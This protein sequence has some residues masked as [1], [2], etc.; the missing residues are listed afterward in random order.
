M[1]EHKKDQIKK[2]KSK[3][4]FHD[5]DWSDFIVVPLVSGIMAIA[6]FIMHPYAGVLG[7]LCAGFLCYYTY[8]REKES[9]QTTLVAIENLNQDFDE[10]TKS[11]VFSMP[12]PIAIL[13][14]SGVF[15][16]YNTSFKNLFN[17]ES[18][19]IGESHEKIFDGISLDAFDKKNDIPFSFEIGDSIYLFYHNLVKKGD[20]KTV[21]LYGIDNTED[22]NVRRLWIDEK[23]VVFSILI[24]NYDELRAKTSEEDRPIVFAKIDRLINQY[25]Q[26]YEAYLTKYE[27]DRYV[28]IMEHSMYLRAESQK[29]YLLDDIRAIKSDSK[30]NPTISMGIGIGL[31]NPQELQREAHTAID[32]AL[33]RGGDQV[34][35]KN[36]DEIKYFGGK[37]QATERL[38]K[39]KARVMANA[40]SQFIDEASEVFIMGHKNPD[41]DSYGS[42]L[43]IRELVK[44]RAKNAYVV[45]DQVTPAIENLYNKAKN[46]LPELNESVISP[47]Q[48]VEKRK[49]SSLI[50]VLDNHRHDSTACPELLD[51][52]NRIIIIDH[53]RRGADY[54]DNAVISY[55][56]PYASSASE[57]VTELLGYVD[58]QFKLPQVVAEGLLAGI[59][60]DTKNFFYQAGVRTF[61]A[62]AFLKR[63]G[64]DSM[65]VKQLFKDD[66]KLIQ[67]RSEIISS[68]ESYKNNTIIGYFK[69]DVEGSTLIASQAADDLLGVRNVEASFVLT[70]SNGRVH[71]SARSLGNVS[72]QLIMERIGGGGHLAASATQLD[73][74]MDKA[75]QLLKKAIDEYFIEEG[76]DESN[77][78]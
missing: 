47:A 45:L 74:D 75:D 43:G 64:A 1:S 57:L 13:N 39:V 37:T 24:D 12:F 36:G 7:L 67:Y 51:Y 16:W 25:A 32:I 35:V 40:I 71:I 53:H 50:L 27:S 18:T 78:T 30:I 10:I 68:A 59:T 26:E 62:A 23:P 8:I 48:A 33:S 21:L 11:A 20:E 44:K 19:V 52:K 42:C 4:G 6:L 58:E 60:V 5:V 29:F 73:M 41:M 46:D 49:D 15:L 34:V 3:N 17:I 69:Q 61:E 63:Q 66:F 38:S 54:I 9:R 22:E 76:E 55:I 31:V 77:L 2:P 70:L 14:G 56:E 72:V 65:V 28:M